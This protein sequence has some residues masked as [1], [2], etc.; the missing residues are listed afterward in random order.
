MKNDNF[1]ELLSCSYAVK[2]FLSIL[3]DSPKANWFSWKSYDADV[4]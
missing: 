3:L 4:E 1:T 2:L